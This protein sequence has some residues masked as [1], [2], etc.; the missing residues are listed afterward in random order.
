MEQEGIQEDLSD[1]QANCVSLQMY[2]LDRGQVELKDEYR[3]LE[4]VLGTADRE[5]D[6]V[7][8]R[9]SG[10]G[11]YIVG[12]AWQFHGMYADGTYVSASVLRYEGERF[13]GV[14][15]GYGGGLGFF[16]CGYHRPDGYAGRHRRV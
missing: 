4:G 10:D 1:S 12:S 16:R 7:F 11:I 2:E 9:P 15:G 6:W 3:I 8:F 5:D 14:R 13:C